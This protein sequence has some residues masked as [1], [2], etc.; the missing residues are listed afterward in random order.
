MKTY[1]V[2]YANVPKNYY[3]ASGI[4]DCKIMWN[5]DMISCLSNNFDGTWK[6]MLKFSIN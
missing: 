5:L 4:E 2:K 1:Y 6:V 3:I